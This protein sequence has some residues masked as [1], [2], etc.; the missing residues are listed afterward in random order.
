MAQ[1]IN[2]ECVGHLNSRPTPPRV[3]PVVPQNRA[4]DHPPV[5]NAEVACAQ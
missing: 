5:A 1:P 4:V 3:P 2:P